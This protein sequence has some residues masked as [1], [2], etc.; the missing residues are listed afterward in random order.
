MAVMPNIVFIEGINYRKKKPLSQMSDCHGKIYEC[1]MLF[2][3]A[4]SVYN[5]VHAL[6]LLSQLIF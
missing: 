6:V 2:A 1:L 3:N 4:L 5:D